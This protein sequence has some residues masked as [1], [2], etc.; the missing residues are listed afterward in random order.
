MSDYI[1]TIT[2]NQDFNTADVG[3]PNTGAPGTDA[4]TGLLRRKFNFGD[5]VSELAIAQDIDPE[6]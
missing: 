5:Q 2:P 3:G 6:T 1:S 4:N